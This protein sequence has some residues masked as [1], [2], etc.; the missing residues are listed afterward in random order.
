ME[1]TFSER[2]IQACDDHPLIPDYG[3]GSQV[4]VAEKLGVSQEAVRKYFNN[5]SIPRPRKMKILAEFLGVSE[6]W[7][8]LGVT[9]TLDRS[10]RKEMMRVTKGAV[11]MLAG[12]ISLEGGNFA[13]PTP[14]DSRSNVSI[15]MRLKTVTK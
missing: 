7:L 2:L 5:E 6:E 15:C 13:F 4:T 11:H 3:H 9:S 12:M 14:D 10:A 1:T 8:S